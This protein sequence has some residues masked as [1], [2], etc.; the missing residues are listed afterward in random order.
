M[1]KL[2]WSCAAVAVAAAG[3]VYL[4]AKHVDQHPYAVMGQTVRAMCGAE[5]DTPGPTGESTVPAEPAPA[6]PLVT[7]ASTAPVRGQIVAV[8]ESSLPDHITVREGDA[9]TPISSTGSSPADMTKIDA[10]AMPSCGPMKA[11][12]PL[13]MPYCSDDSCPPKRMPYADEESCERSEEQGC[14]E[15]S[16]GFF[17]MLMGFF[18]NLGPIEPKTDPMPAGS[19]PMGP[20]DKGLSPFGKCQ[21]DEHYHDHYPCCP[22]T[23]RCYPYD[24]N[25][26][27][28]PAVP[29]VPEQK[30]PAEKCSPKKDKAEKLPPPQKSS[31][32]EEQEQTSVS[33][34]HLD[35]MEFR[36]SDAG[37]HRFIPGAL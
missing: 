8:A 31:V 12:C 1:R 26:T 25:P 28:S 37:L 30:K 35:T 3:T 22:Y 7:G 33:E 20:S 6:D 13:V 29:D 23:G 16:K 15:E 10:D 21:E 34:F 19:E 27:P 9:G 17:E 24:P 36:P 5:H 14:E 18:W 32:L 11:S 4:A 2:F